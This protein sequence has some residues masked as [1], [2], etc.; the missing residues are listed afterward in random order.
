[1]LRH[2]WVALTLAVAMI[3]AAPNQTIGAE[4]SQEP[5]PK[6]KKRAVVLNEPRS[7]QGYTLVSPMSSTKSYL[8]DMEGKIV[9][10]WVGTGTPALTAY[11]LPTGNLLRP[12]SGEALSFRPNGGIYPKGRIQEFTWNG[13]LV[14]D[15]AFQSHNDIGKRTYTHD[16]IKLPNGNVLAVMMVEKTAAEAAAAGRKTSGAVMAESLLELKPSG[17]N[18]A[19]IVWEWHIWDHLIQDHDAARANYG[20]VADHPERIDI[21]FGGDTVDNLFGKKDSAKGKGGGALRASGNNEFKWSR[22]LDRS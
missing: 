8:I 22:I 6:A 10:T 5:A 13:E 15:F 20:N 4:L 1:M 16:M 19:Q 11:L 2:I 14:W 18:D 7:F 12:C 3:F 9:H 21:N 17:K